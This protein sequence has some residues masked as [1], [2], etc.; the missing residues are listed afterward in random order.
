MISQAV[1][2]ITLSLLWG[3]VFIFP[4]REYSTHSRKARVEM[5]GA[6]LRDVVGV[7]P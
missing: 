2:G 5:K 4:R 3:D 7:S 1:N 6:I